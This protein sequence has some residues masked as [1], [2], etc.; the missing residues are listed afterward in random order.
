MVPAAGPGRLPL[1]GPGADLSADPAGV[2]VPVRAARA[3]PENCAPPSPHG[4]PR[5]LLLWKMTPASF[6]S[7][8]GFPVAIPPHATLGGA[9]LFQILLSAHGFERRYR[10]DLR[11]VAVQRARPGRLPVRRSPAGR[12]VPR[13]RRR[14]QARP[15][16]FGLLWFFLALLPTSLVPLAEV[17]NDHRM[18][19][20]FVGLAL[21]VFWSLRLLVI[22]RPTPGTRRR[23][24]HAA[25]AGLQPP[26]A[27]TRAT[28][29]GG[30][31][32]RCGATSP[33]RAP[34]T[35]AA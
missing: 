27:P 14:K 32:N 12:G 24:R 7:G 3:R 33:S 19:F 35:A 22:A 6:R 34:G 26:S 10:L 8:R 29:S 31:R 5:S 16:A 28:S 30:P 4:S 9:A 2:R 25:G 23:G 17:T 21:A 1:E 11:F 18:F 15:I 13:S 20:P